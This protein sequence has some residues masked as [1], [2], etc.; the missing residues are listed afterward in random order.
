MSAKIRFQS[1][2][3]TGIVLAKVGNPQREESL[4]TSRE[5]FKVSADDQEAL[6]ALFLKP[7]KNLTAHRFAHH[8]NLDHHEMNSISRSLFTA[9]GSLLEKGCE[10]ASRLYSKSNHPNIKSGDL[11]I[12]LIDDIELDGDHVQGLCILKAESTVPFLSIVARDGDLQLSTDQGINPDKIDKGCLILNHNKDDGYY[13]LTFD[14]GGAE[15]R[16]WIREFLGVQPVPDAAFLT[17]AYTDMAVTFLETTAEPAENEDPPPWEPA[18]VAREALEYFGGREFFDVAEFE[19]VVLKKPDVIGKFQAHR[20]KV[21]ESHG[22]PLQTTFEISPKELKKAQ[23]KIHSVMKLDTGVEIHVKVKE[24]E[25]LL[26]R[27]FDEAKGM[28]FI[29]VYYNELNTA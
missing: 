13:V 7:F 8:S 27:G 20:A 16:F 22:Q 14:R 12:S 11:C 1:A 26:E 24:Q 23:R 2:A 3:T 18:I 4:Q 25:P 6:T 19:E 28:K 5:V 17:T 9:P 10:I 21:E 29:K 15:S